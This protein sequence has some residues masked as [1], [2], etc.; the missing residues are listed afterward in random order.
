MSVREIDIANALKA[1]HENLE[2]I[3]A[4]QVKIGP[5]GS[6]IMDAVAIKKT[7]SPRT[8]IGYEIKTSRQDFLNDQK[9]PVYMEN[10]NIFY[11]V[12]PKDIIKKGELPEGAGHM[13]YNSDT[14]KLRT[15]IKAPFRDTPISSDVL[16]HIM[17]WKFNRYLGFKTRAEML[18]DYKATKELKSLGID[19]ARKIRELEFDL[20][21][22]KRDLKSVREDN[23]YYRK[24]IGKLNKKIEDP[25][26]GLSKQ[27]IFL[28]Q[29]SVRN[30]SRIADKIKE[31]E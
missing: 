31:A 1:K 3:F 19:I 23:V 27:D 24:S 4:T 12:T 25:V 6:R 22:S 15:S 2:D 14:N 28:L 11:F 29:S 18:E 16:L 20:E 5:A 17:F 13:V 7:W 10:C 21:R 8:V 9:Y 30:L 26:E